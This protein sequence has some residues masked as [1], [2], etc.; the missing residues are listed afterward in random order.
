MTKQTTPDMVQTSEN[1]YI[2]NGFESRNDYLIFLSEEYG[3]GLE[4]VHA[5]ADLLGESEDFDGLVNALEDAESD[6]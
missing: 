1:I 5:L 4:T 2:E 6:F 3:V